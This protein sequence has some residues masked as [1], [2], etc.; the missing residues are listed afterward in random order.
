MSFPV[1]K[2]A[3]TTGYDAYLFE[4]ACNG[5][6][7]ALVRAVQTRASGVNTKAGVTGAL[8]N[9][10]RLMFHHQGFVTE[11]RGDTF[12][13]LFIQ[14]AGP[15]LRCRVAACS[16]GA[17]PEKGQVVPSSRGIPSRNWWL[18]IEDVAC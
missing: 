12:V 14:P 1:F 10:R 11:R 4:G 2:P 18:R 8:K 9:R 13:G 7:R 17:P 5:R 16:T 15:G 3:V 6:Q